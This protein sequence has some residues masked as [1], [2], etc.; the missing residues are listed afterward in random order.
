M[1]TLEDIA[2]LAHRYDFVTLNAEEA[3]QSDADYQLRY[4]HEAGERDAC[5]LK[6]DEDYVIIR[7]A[8]GDVCY[9]GKSLEKLE[10]RMV[11]F[12]AEYV[13]ENAET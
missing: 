11:G 3:Q 2:A 10:R 8:R 6:V 5:T 4:F 13:S 9:D 12:F 1:G 7:D